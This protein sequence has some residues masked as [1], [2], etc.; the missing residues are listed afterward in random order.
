MIC[1]GCGK[2]LPD[3]AKFCPFCGY[4][5]VNALQDVPPA[6]PKKESETQIVGREEIDW[7]KETIFSDHSEEEVMEEEGEDEEISKSINGFAGFV[8][9]AIILFTILF[10]IIGIPL[11][12]AGEK[13]KEN[14]KEAF[15]D[16][17]LVFYDSYEIITEN[18]KIYLEIN[19]DM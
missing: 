13:N 15:E 11:I 14:S 2:E 4:R 8:I 19:N 9:I 17:E 6:I 18:G 16:D 5:M 12:A 1:K 3:K 7:S 10:V